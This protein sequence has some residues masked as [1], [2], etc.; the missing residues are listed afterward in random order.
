MKNVLIGI[1]T[2]WVVVG[3]LVGLGMLFQTHPALA[4]AL[5]VTAFGAVAG[6]LFPN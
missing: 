6:F 1:T 4:I 3:T 2:I 5:C